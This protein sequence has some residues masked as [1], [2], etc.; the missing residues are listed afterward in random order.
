MI[1]LKNPNAWSCLPTAFAIALGVSVEAVIATVGH[2]GSEITHAGLPEP[3][4]RRGFH[5]QEM[6]KMCL[7]DDMSVTPIELAP[8]SIASRQIPHSPKVFDTGGWDWFTENL[9]YSTGVIECRTPM[10]R[11][12]AMAYQG[13]GHFSTI[14]D[15]A[16]GDEFLFFGPEDTEKRNRFLVSLWRLEEIQQ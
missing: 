10:G 7:Q 15:P 8:Q 12:H 4:N 3:L 5:P 11:G 16:T 14:Y 1:P 9:F 6:I 13:E 2:D